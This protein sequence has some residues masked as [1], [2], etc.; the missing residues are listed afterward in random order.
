MEVSALLWEVE[1]EVHNLKIKK[2]LKHTLQLKILFPPIIE[3]TH[4][5]NLFLLA[6]FV[7]W[8]MQ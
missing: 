8:Q 4:I 6:S 5:D 3:S 7:H 2:Q 1:Y